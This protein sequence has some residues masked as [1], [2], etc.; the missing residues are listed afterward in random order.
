MISGGLDSTAAL[1]WMLTNT[2][3]VIHAHHI[4]LQNRE[5]RAKAESQALANILPYLRENYRPFQYTE[6][7]VDMGKMF[8]PFDLFVYSF[9]SG[10]I[11][12][13]LKGRRAIHRIVTGSIQTRIN[14]DKRR[15]YAWGLF[16]YMADWSAHNR[17][18]NIDWYRPLIGMT[19]EEVYDFLPKELSD[20][21]WSCRYPK[22]DDG[23]NA[24]TCGKCFSCMATKRIRGELTQEEIKKY[25]KWVE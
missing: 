10:V 17:N 25:K 2:D 7:S 11:V 8:I 22:Y 24:T 15:E 14:I 6:S 9:M 4:K 18:R 12:Q 23:D 21:T 20:M 16:R 3:D 13:G 19:K 1:V 5:N